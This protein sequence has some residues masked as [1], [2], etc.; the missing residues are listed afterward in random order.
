MARNTM[1]YIRAGDTEPLEITVSA[2]GVSSLDDADTVVLYAREA[3]AETNHVDGAACTVSDSAAMEVTF[4]PVGA[5]S[6]GGNAFD[7]PGTYLCYVKITWTDGDITRHPARDDGTLT[8][9]VTANLE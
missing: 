7:E 4:D 9:T 8:I 3:S 5:K 2:T 6:G 1:T